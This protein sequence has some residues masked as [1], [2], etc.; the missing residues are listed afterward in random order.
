MQ[1]TPSGPVR[2]AAAP[3]PPPPPLRL[4]P[5]PPSPPSPPFPPFL[6]FPL[7]AVLSV[8][9]T[10]LQGL[11]IS[12]SMFPK[13]LLWTVERDRAAARRARS[14]RPARA[15]AATRPHS[16]VSVTVL[17]CGR[18][19]VSRQKARTFERE[20]VA[21]PLL[22]TKLSTRKVETWVYLIFYTFLHRLPRVA[23]FHGAKSSN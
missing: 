17:T 23:I 4:L 18:D 10:P 19:L 2:L 21:S 20:I 15:Q 6:P 11:Q 8:G 22:N 12:L 13:G 14:P 16:L 1:T 7:P 9:A 5:F 3:P